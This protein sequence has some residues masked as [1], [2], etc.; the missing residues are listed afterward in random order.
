[1]TS[2]VFN[3]SLI[4][5]VYIPKYIF[6]IAKCLFVGINFLLTLIPLLGVI[7]LTG[8]TPNLLYFFLPVIFLCMLIF[9]IG[10]SLLISTISVFL[11]DMFYI[12][13][14]ILTIWNYVTPIF[15]DISIIPENLQ[16]LF[17]YNPLFIFI[18]SARGIILY[19]S[20]PTIQ[21]ILLMF[22]I[23]IFLF[24]VGALVFKKKQEQFIYYV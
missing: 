6:P 1:M 19:N 24:V 23:S 9:T 13:G 8:C 3:F 14:I 21:D 10:I 4:N 17:R 7:L 18:N 22:G 12:Y 2:V 11:R 16:T 5:K 15:Y 20:M